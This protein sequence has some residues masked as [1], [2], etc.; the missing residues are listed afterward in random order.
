MSGQV[1]G[2]RNSTL[3]FNRETTLFLF[4]KLPKITLT[5]V[6]PVEKPTFDAN[7]NQFAVFDI[8]AK[9][10]LFVYCFAVNKRQFLVVKTCNSFWWDGFEKTLTENCI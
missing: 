1:F 5:R 6:S 8:L 9:L 7:E 10:T 4:P 2:I 3:L